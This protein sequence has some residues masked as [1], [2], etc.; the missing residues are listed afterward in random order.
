MPEKEIRARQSE[1]GSWG[2]LQVIRQLKGKV[3]KIHPGAYVDPQ[4]VVIGDVTMEEG[5]SLWPTAVARGDVHWIKIGRATNI[6]DGSILHVTQG[7]WPLQIGDNCTV[8]H[9]AI[10]HGCTIGNNVLIGMGAIILDGA[11]IEDNV[12]VAAG[13]LVPEG[14]TIPSGTLV[15]GSP[16]KVVRELPPRTPQHR[17]DQAE[18]YWGL[19]QELYSEDNG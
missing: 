12:V 2:D 8:G 16:A 15:M 7:K 1:K 17:V 18:A 5:S 10:L 4:A 9:R 19:W 6:Q 13:S 11:V 14:K 3:P